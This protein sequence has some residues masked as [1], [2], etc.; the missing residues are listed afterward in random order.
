MS[1]QWGIGDSWAGSGGIEGRDRFNVIGGYL[2]MVYARWLIDGE[3]EIRS[4]TPV[5]RG[6]GSGT[7]TFFE[8]AAGE[9]NYIHV[10]VTYRIHTLHSSNFAP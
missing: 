8:R 10:M 9:D 2:T 6:T 7:W 5:A 3:A 1:H 4:R